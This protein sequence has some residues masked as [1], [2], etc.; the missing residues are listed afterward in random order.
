MTSK[1]EEH[2]SVTDCEI[3]RSSNQNFVVESSKLPQS[4][5]IILIVAFVITNLVTSVL[6]VL[7]GFDHTNNQNT[8]L[9]PFLIGASNG[10]NTTI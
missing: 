1:N 3:Q 9:I 7:G 5:K 8:K 10:T 4:I 2:N 6:A